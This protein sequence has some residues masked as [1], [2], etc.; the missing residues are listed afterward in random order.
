[1]GKINILITGCGGFVGR[2][3]SEYF[4]KQPERYTTY[5]T[6]HAD[7]ELLDVEAV[8]S[9]FNNNHVDVVIH[10]AS[11][12]GTRKSNYDKGETSIISTNLKM[13]FNIVR[14]LSPETYMIHL[15]T[16]AEY[17]RRH[18]KPKMPE[19]YFDKHVPADDYGYS[20]YLISKYIEKSNNIICLRI[21]G[22]YGK[23][24]D[25]CSRFISNAIVKN[26]LHL[27][28]TINQ[29]VVFDYLYIDDFV[30]IVESIVQKRV[31][32][33]KHL[34]VTPTQSIDLISIAE[35]INKISDF[36]SDVYVLNEGMN[37]EYTGDNSKLLEN[38]GPYEFTPY[39]K[40]IYELYQYYRARLSILDVKTI[41]EDPYLKYCK[42]LKDSPEG[43]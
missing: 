22:L 35:L 36:Q 34:N 8:E 24:E 7:L 38:I 3:L 32:K 42:V 10:C 2:N 37:L 29:N 39:E 12:G 23:Y 16:G 4:S 6:T 40:G 27:P 43:S 14:C 31:M 20:K 18:N 9:F 1:M 17:D 13:F 28:I 30:T 33:N 41:I 21:F 26:L 15:G 11:V 25:Y 5:A 19:D